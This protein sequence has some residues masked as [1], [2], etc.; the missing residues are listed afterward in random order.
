M[1]LRHSL[2]IILTGVVVGCNSAS[3]SA[4]VDENDIPDGEQ[5]YNKNCIACHGA[6]GTLGK[7]GSKNLQDSQMTYDQV[8][9]MVELGGGNGM[10]RFKEILGRDGEMEA[11]IE[12]VMQMRGR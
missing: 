6:D 2:F 3:N 4:A 11:V 5:L 9:K 8:H 10:P 12:Y 1:V 7:A